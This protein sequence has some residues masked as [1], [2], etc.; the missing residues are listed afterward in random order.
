MKIVFG[1]GRRREVIEFPTGKAVGVTK[2]HVQDMCRLLRIK[3]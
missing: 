3:G 2:E 1:S